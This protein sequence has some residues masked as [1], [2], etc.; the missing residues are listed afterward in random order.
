M[1]MVV[2]VAANLAFQVSSVPW[3]VATWQ[4]EGRGNHRAIVEV[5]Q[6]ADAV[7]VRIPWLQARPV[8]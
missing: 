8:P 4:E 3:Q 5:T 2:A 1:L 7:R 6:P